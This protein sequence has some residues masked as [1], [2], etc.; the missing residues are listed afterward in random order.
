MTRGEY[1]AV[2]RSRLEGRVSSHVEIA[3]VLV[4]LAVVVL[5]IVAVLTLWLP[6]VGGTPG[7]R[8]EGDDMARGQRPV[9]LYVSPARDRWVV[10]WD[11][12]TLESTHA[13]LSAAIAAARRA[14]ARMPPGHTSQ[15]LV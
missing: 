8:L 5:L 13:T 15:I 2:L 14:V 12:G 11:G 7:R 3:E 10:K 9:T 6:T 4:E 1:L